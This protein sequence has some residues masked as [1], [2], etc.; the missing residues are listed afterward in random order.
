MRLGIG[1]ALLLASHSAAAAP[2]SAAHPRLAVTDLKAGSG[3]DD[4]AGS[5]LSSVLAADAARLGF[6]V[7]AQSEIASMLG[8]QKER[9]A[10]GCSEDGCLVDIAGALG[11]EFVLSGELARVGSRAHISLALLQ[12]GKGKVAARSAG[13]A[14]GDDD[15]VA[16][17]VIAHFR[18]LVGQVRPDLLEKAPPVERPGAEHLRARRT[19]SYWTLGAG[20]LLLAG[21]TGTGLWARAQ[22]NNLK[23]AWTASDYKARYDQQRHTAL[24]AD[25]LFG[26]GVVTAGIGAW[27]YFTSDVPVVALPVVSRDGAGL[28]IAGH[29]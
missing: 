25:I 1:L 6:D 13:F 4:R 8:Y 26:A 14:E 11:A 16:L 24:A 15:E 12:P 20:G 3:V 28:A 27:L 10:L 29:F 17:A 22:A 2:K 23:S 21:G 19:A 7:I 18:A 9:A 5:S